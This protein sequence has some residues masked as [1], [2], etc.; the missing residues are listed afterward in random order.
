MKFLIL[1]IALS[2][3]AAFAGKCLS[4][5]GRIADSATHLFNIGAENEIH[6]MA[7]G[8]RTSLT[9]LPVITVM[10]ARYAFEAKY[11]YPCGPAPREPK[12]QML[13]NQDCK[14]VNLKLE[15]FELY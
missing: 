11:Y 2:S 4:E 6:C 7:V 14:I 8:G 1:A 5:A 10:P 13:L 9:A 3:S 12:V 15:G